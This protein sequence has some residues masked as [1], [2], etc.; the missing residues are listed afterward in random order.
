MSEA[1]EPVGTE[2]VPP[3]AVGSGVEPETP[4]GF[5]PQ[6]KY[7]ANL[8]RLTDLENKAKTAE[9]E[10][11]Q[12][13]RLIN[14][15]IGTVAPPANDA[16][17]EFTSAVERIEARLQHQAK[18]GATQEDRDWALYELSRNSFMRGLPNQ[19]E[20]EITLRDVPAADRPEVQKL[21]KELSHTGEKV[22][23]GLAAEILRLR[24]GISPNTPLKPDPPQVPPGTSMRPAPTAPA[25]PNV[26]TQEQFDREWAN[27]TPAR[28]DELYRLDREGK[29]F[30][31]S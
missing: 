2:P 13:Q 3:A 22:S 29:L 30:I 31:K 26:M 1:P 27:G 7:E 9:G 23:I 18:F 19:L 16:P 28:K 4:E 14:E 20:R 25:N 12:L 5:V 17:D 11:D 24:K 21:Q 6:D 10:R 15:R 8:Q